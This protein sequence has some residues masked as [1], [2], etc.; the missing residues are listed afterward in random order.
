MDVMRSFNDQDLLV[1]STAFHRMED[2]PAKR[3]LL[4]LIR[5]LEG[6]GLRRAEVAGAIWDQVEPIT[7]SGRVTDGMQLRVIGKG[8]VER[9][10]PLKPEILQALEA[11]RD[12][13]QRLYEAGKLGRFWRSFDG[14][15]PGQLPLIGVL[16]ER[17]IE[18]MD[19]DLKEAKA[20]AKAGEPLPSGLSSDV[21]PSS[22]PDEQI[23]TTGALSAAALYRLLKEFFKKCAVLSGEDPNDPR[24]V[25]RRASTH[26]LRHTYAH[27]AL[28][29]SG[30]D[31]PVVQQILGHRSITTTAI[32]VKADMEA[33]KRTND[34]INL[35]L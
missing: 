15:D 27:H 10:V 20:Q 34:A 22:H 13:R 32:Y 1:I 28:R 23:N 12:D 21:N 16:D 31:L 29:E 33:R 2:G 30:K 3:R 17:W 11:H 5:L 35:T 9:L 8:R 6:A 4:A 19:R 25:F 26:W 7:I 14:K 18:T 24:S